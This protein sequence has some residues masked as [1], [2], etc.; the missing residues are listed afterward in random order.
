MIV[1]VPK[2]KSFLLQWNKNVDG[3][4]SHMGAGH[5]WLLYGCRTRTVHECGALWCPQTSPF[6]CL[7]TAR[8]CVAAFA[9]DGEMLLGPKTNLQ[10]GRRLSFLHIGE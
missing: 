2:R 10:L 6:T 5:L 8:R 4:Q 3:T 7:R 9:E 1:Q